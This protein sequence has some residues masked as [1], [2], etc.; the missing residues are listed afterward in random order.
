MNLSQVSPDLRRERLNYLRFRMRVIGNAALFI[1][2]LRR[3][4][5][6]SDDLKMSARELSL[7][8]DSVFEVVTAKSSFEKK[9]W[10]TW[11]PFL[12]LCLWFTIYTTPAIMLYPDLNQSLYNWL[13]VNELAWII[14]MIRMLVFN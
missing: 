13:F 1:H 12:S 7:S 6:K 11:T 4:I 5:E 14:E 8:M 10:A 3:N 9:F 2:L